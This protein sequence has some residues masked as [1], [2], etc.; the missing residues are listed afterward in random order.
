VRLG[1]RGD[2]GT[3]GGT[4]IECDARRAAIEEE[5][6]ERAAVDTGFEEQARDVAGIGN[7]R[8]EVKGID[9]TGGHR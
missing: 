4:G 2:A 3:G 9:A 7:V 6:Q 8:R 1:G 5:P